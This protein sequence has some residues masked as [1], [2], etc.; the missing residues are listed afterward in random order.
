MKKLLIK[1]EEKRIKAYEALNHKFFKTGINVGNLLRGKF[2][3]NKNILKTLL[4]RKTVELHDKKRS[5]FRDVVIA[6]ITLNFSE[7]NE[8]NQARQIFMEMTEGDKHFL[9]KKNLLFLEWEKFV[10]I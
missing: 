9:I 4:K 6:Y 7:Q 1:D 8:E 2:K 5:K 3:E 10:E